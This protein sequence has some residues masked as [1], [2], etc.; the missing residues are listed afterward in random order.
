MASTPTTPYSLTDSGQL[1]NVAS[2]GGLPEQDGKWS[3]FFPKEPE[4]GLFR[5]KKASASDA[6]VTPR[7]G[8]EKRLNG[9]SFA[10]ARA[11]LPDDATFASLTNGQRSERG[12][13]R[14]GDATFAPLTVG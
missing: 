3:V 7:R 9:V 2:P 12:V 6:T 4:L 1:G 13:G 14:P 11:G 10:F 5:A 8:M